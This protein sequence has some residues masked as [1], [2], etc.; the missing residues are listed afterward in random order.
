MAAE[1]SDLVDRAEYYRQLAAAVR[2]RAASMKTPEARDA[3]ATVAS[4]YELLAHYA[5]SLAPARQL[6]DT[7]F[8]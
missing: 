7:D 2:A 3:L 6:G 4:D 5:E 8:S 1:F